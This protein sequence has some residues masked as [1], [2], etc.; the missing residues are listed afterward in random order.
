M[1]IVLLTDMLSKHKQLYY[2]SDN[3]TMTLTL[4]NFGLNQ[5]LSSQRVSQLK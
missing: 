5:K 3:E 1:L 4:T 2:D